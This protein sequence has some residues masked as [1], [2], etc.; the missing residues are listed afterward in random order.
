LFTVLLVR[1]EGRVCV[2]VVG[3][4]GFGGSSGR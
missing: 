4:G 1:R 2:F 3:S